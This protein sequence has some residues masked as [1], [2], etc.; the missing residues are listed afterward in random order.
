MFFLRVI[1]HFM[2]LG[3]HSVGRLRF[4]VCDSFCGG[5]FEEGVYQLRG[6]CY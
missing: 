4:H 3:D 5:G 6:F 1:E 2:V